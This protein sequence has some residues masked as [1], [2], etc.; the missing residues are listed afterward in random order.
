[1]FPFNFHTKD[2][3]HDDG[4]INRKKQLDTRII[5]QHNLEQLNFD[6]F[7]VYFALFIEKKVIRYFIV[8]IL[9]PI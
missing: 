2:Y 7:Y 4:H 3:N 8:S 1:M 6:L 5:K 9:L